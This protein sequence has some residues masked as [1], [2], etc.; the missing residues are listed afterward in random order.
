MSASANRRDSGSIDHVEYLKR[1][2]LTVEIFRFFQPSVTNRRSGF[3]SI[4]I[5][6]LIILRCTRERE[7]ERR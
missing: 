3:S 2:R 1:V 4:V 5:E 7:R 6:L